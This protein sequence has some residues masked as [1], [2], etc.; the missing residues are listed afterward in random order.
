MS[1]KLPTDSHPDITYYRKLLRF[2]GDHILYRIRRLAPPA[3]N[4][5]AVVRVLCWG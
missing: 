4:F 5:Q 3:A 1:A 2:D